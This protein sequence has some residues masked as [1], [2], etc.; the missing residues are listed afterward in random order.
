VPTRDPAADLVLDLDVPVGGRMRTTWTAPIGDARGWAWVQHGFGRRASA[1]AGLAQL[2]AGD[3]IAVV[4]PDIA[5]WRPRRSMHDATWLTAASL[6]IAHAVEVGLPQ[7]RGVG[8]GTPA[9]W[10]LL[11]HSAGGAVVGH[12]AACMEARVT[13]SVAGMVLLDP[14][15][16]VGGLLAGVLPALDESLRDR[17][18]VH[19]CRPSRCNRQGATVAELRTQGWSLID[20]P[21]LSHADP[22]RIPGSV[23]GPALPADPWAARMCG[24]PGSG[25]DVLALAAAVRAEV[26]AAYP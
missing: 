21:G 6:T 24:R 16:T 10:V 14:V 26:G 4:R 5:W 9:R 23:S 2:L 12:A 25:A 1:L 7:E 17:S 15:D 20:H 3:G 22:E 13:D 18:T 11:G 19:A 8:R